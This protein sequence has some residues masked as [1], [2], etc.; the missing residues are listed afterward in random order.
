M[1]YAQDCGQEGYP[2]SPPKQGFNNQS[3]PHNRNENI[4]GS[5]DKGYHQQQKHRPSMI[6][7]QQQREKN[8]PPPWL[9]ENTKLLEQALEG[10]EKELPSSTKKA[11]KNVELKDDEREPLVKEG[12]ERKPIKPN[13][14]GENAEGPFEAE[15]VV[16]EK[17]IVK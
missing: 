1:S 9:R 16:K 5:S 6:T 3:N 4:E 17:E 12:N 2:H 15:G 8:P 7:H 13:E 14:L 11:D 10:H